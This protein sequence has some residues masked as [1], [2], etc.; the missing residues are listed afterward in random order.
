MKPHLPKSIT[1]NTSPNATTNYMDNQSDNCTLMEE[2]ILN[3]ENTDYTYILHSILVHRGTTAAGGHY[4]TYI[5]DLEPFLIKGDD[6]LDSGKGWLK[7]DDEHVC[8]VAEEYVYEDSFGKHQ[9]ATDLTYLE[10]VSTAYMLVYIKKA[11]MKEIYMAPDAESEIT[12]SLFI[13]RRKTA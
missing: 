9:E 2:G 11:N 6:Y 4:Y 10:E 12:K 3:D 7:F 13:E 5:R 8:E 1:H